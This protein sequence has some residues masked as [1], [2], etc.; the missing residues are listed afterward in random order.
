MDPTPIERKQRQKEAL[1]AKLQPQQPV[2]P[3]F[4]YAYHQLRISQTG[5][6]PRATGVNKRPSPLPTSKHVSGQIELSQTID[7]MQAETTAS[8]SVSL[9]GVAEETLEPLINPAGL[10]LFN[11]VVALEWYPSAQYLRQLKWAFKRAAE[12]LYDATDGLFTFGKVAFV[13][14]EFM[15]CADIQILASNRLAPRSWVGG[16]YL[17]EKFMP[18]RLGRGLWTKINR[19]TIPWVEPEGYRTLVHEWAHYALGVRDAYLTNALLRLRTYD[20]NG[21]QIHQEHNVVSPGFSP[22]LQSIMSTLEG[23]S[24]LAPLRGAS[25]ERKREFWEQVRSTN[26]YKFFGPALDTKINDPQ[27]SA[28]P[29]RLP[30]PFP[31]M[32]VSEELEQRATQA[33]VIIRVPEGIAWEHCWVYVLKQ[34]PKRR[35]ID[36]GTFESGSQNDGFELL[37]AGAGDTILLVGRHQPDRAAAAQPQIWC[38]TLSDEGDTDGYTMVAWDDVAVT[39]AQFPLIDVVPAELDSEEQKT[40]RQAKVKVACPEAANAEVKVFPL[41]QPQSNLPYTSAPQKIPTLDG[42]VLVQWGDVHYPQISIATFSQGGNPPSGTPTV[43]PP[44]TAGSSEGNVMIFFDPNPAG[45]SA[46]LSEEEK[47]RIAE[48]KIVTTRMHI[49]DRWQKLRDGAQARG[50]VFSLASNRDLRNLIDYCPTLVMNY[51]PQTADDDGDLWIYRHL[52]EDERQPGADEWVPV[53]TGHPA[54]AFYMVA[55]LNEA[56][57]PR[58]FTANVPHVDRYRLYWKPRRTP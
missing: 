4:T 17:D 54:G 34:D 14:P 1:K 9:D 24:E 3:V 48:T 31:E 52:H 58:L 23:V 41:G 16:L 35:L 11:A 27:V 26:E 46:P 57:A 2:D 40:R 25:R 15:E 12:F 36:Q 56:T 39:P 6:A 33:P 5:T 51:E 53:A 10:C 55:P 44:I 29:E 50:Y 32:I 21:N 7:P 20:A 13:G 30:L 37:G 38:G 28:G 42:L 18:I 45:S 47:E 22:A 8:Y 19:F 43:G 49:G